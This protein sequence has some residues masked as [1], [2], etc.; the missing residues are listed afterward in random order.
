M[1]KTTA[2]LITVDVNNDLF[3]FILTHKNSKNSY[4]PGLT[5]NSKLGVQKAV[6]SAVL[7]LPVC[8]SKQACHIFPPCYF[9][10]VRGALCKHLQAS[11][12]RAPF[13]ISCARKA[14]KT[15]QGGSGWFSISI[16]FPA[17][18]Y[19]LGGFGAPFVFSLSTSMTSLEERSYLF[20]LLLLVYSTAGTA[21]FRSHG[22]S[23][24]RY[25]RANK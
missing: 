17:E 13:E 10:H 2:I 15:W 21:N 8:A 7:Y 25:S 18:K 16:A 24:P 9:A 5:V 23:S 12:S 19:V 20:L 3:G 14:A 1:I 11:C 6:D 4:Y 22:C